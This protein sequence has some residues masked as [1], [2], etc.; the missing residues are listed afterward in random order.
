MPVN[1]RALLRVYDI[2][3]DS[4]LDPI[5]PIRLHHWLHMSVPLLHSRLKRPT[6]ARKLVIHQY[7]ILLVAIWR[8]SGAGQGKVVLTSNARIRHVCVRIELPRRGIAPWRRIVRKLPSS[9]D[10]L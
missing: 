10:G 5:A 8:Y 3:R 7:H 2:V 9:L 6:H 1:S 4:D